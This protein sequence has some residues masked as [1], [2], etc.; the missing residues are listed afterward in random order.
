[1]AAFVGQSI[2]LSRKYHNE[3]VHYRKNSLNL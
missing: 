2:D 1:M 3:K